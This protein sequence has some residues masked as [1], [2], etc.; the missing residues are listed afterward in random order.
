M[1][2]KLNLGCG[3]NILPDFE[4]HDADCD[5]T[6]PLPWSD[7]SI[8]YIAI[9][10]CVEHV[11]GPDAFRFFNEAYRILEPCGILRVCVPIL[12]RLADDH[13]RDIIL[14]HGH[15]MVYNEANLTKMLKLAG[16]RLV[17]PTPFDPNIDGH[18]KVIG[19]DKDGIETLRLEAVK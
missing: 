6:K 19:V 15:L 16:F 12:D 17:E 2:K 11:S 5:I 10:H 7:G 9:E 1:A 13:A 3:G 4:N 14:G 8:G 18:W